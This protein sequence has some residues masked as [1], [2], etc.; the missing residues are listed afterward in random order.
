MK[1][2]HNHRPQ[3]LKDAEVHPEP[4]AL[5]S[6]RQRTGSTEP[7]THESMASQPEGT[8]KGPG[9][10]WMAGHS[11]GFVDGLAQGQQ[12]LAE[13]QVQAEAARG[14]TEGYE[15]GL[16]QARED[17]KVQL[18]R[19]ADQLQIAA[20][21]AQLKADAELS[22]KADQLGRLIA[23]A[24]AEWAT[25]LELAEDDMVAL[26]FDVVCKILGRQLVRAEGI[27]AMVAQ[28]IAEWPGEG[29]LAVHVHPDDLDL[30]NQAR[31]IEVADSLWSSKEARSQ[32]AVEWVP[33]ASVGHAGCVVRSSK[34]GLDARLGVRLEGLLSALR[35][36]RHQVQREPHIGHLTATRA[37]GMVATTETPGHAADTIV[38]AAA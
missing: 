16:A 22:G 11:A 37:L 36:A 24:Q 12:Q 23:A 27:R 8:A 5:P 2:H 13:K 19:Q 1:T 20:A 25:R 7:A 17:A 21:Q 29:E 30:L 32:P 33:D 14:F 10:E 4:L 9:A 6:R 15:A 35:E 18:S 26:C 28:A 3:V 34:G 31:A 38:K